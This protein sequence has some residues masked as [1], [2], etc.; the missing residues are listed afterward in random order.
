MTYDQYLRSL[1]AKRLESRTVDNRTTVRYPEV[2][3]TKGEQT[4]G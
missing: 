1:R 3:R 4:N 2:W